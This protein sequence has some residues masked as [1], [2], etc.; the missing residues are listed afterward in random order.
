MT[1]FFGRLEIQTMATA[2]FDRFFD[3]PPE[4]R[5][6]IISHLVLT[7]H[8]IS[9]KPL[10][11]EQEPHHPMRIPFPHA[12]FLS[13]PSIY[14]TASSLYY[15]QNL[16]LLDLV[17]DSRAQTERV[18][19][20]TKSSPLQA[21]YNPPTRQRI[22]HLDVHHD[23]RLGPSFERHA[24]PA[25]ADMILHGALRHLRFFV[26]PKG[27]TDAPLYA[28][29]LAENPLA[30]PSE[31]SSR[32]RFDQAACLSGSSSARPPPPPLPPVSLSG[33]RREAFRDLTPFGAMMRL[34][35][36]P[37]LETAELWVT[38]VH[39]RHFCAFHDREA[40]CK[41]GAQGSGG[42]WGFVKVDWRALA[43]EYLGDDD[44]EMNILKV[45][46]R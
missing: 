42:V 21:L 26:F 5:G 30:P 33:R 20:A 7:P 32:G 17:P 37:Y 1:I 16:F 14:T 4:I 44:H 11:T 13:H 24:R 46:G 45:G 15:E 43:R 39:Q 40:P 38:P 31:Q 25:L 34:L 10:L 9:I 12:L 19:S 3:L 35:A 22:R 27:I 2:S 18:L 8:P 6:Q 23:N 36:D 28:Q 41:Y 29:V